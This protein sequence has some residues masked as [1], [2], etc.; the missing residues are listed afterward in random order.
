MLAVLALGNWQCNTMD[1]WCCRLRS[2]LTALLV[3]ESNEIIFAVGVF[4]CAKGSSDI[5]GILYNPARPLLTL[6][7]SGLMLV[8]A[9]NVQVSYYYKFKVCR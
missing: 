2:S 7:Y 5:T 1:I 8:V 4:R 3:L 6:I 9:S